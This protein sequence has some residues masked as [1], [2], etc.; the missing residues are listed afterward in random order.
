MSALVYQFKYTPTEKLPPSDIT[1]AFILSVMKWQA[2]CNLQPNIYCFPPNIISPQVPRKI[3]EGIQKM[4]G[5]VG[6]ILQ[7]YINSLGRDF[8]EVLIS[9]G[10]KIAGPFKNFE[11]MTFKEKEQYPLVLSCETFLIAKFVDKNRFGDSVVY[12]T[13][14]WGIEYCAGSYRFEGELLLNVNIKVTLF[15]SLTKEKMIVK[16]ISIPVQPSFYKY[17]IYVDEE[18]RVDPTTG[19]RFAT[20]KEAKFLEGDDQRPQVLAKALESIYPLQLDQFSK[21]FDPKEI[22]QAKTDAEKVRK[23]RGYSEG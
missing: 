23:I 2:F 22:E 14:P 3:Q 5:E 13:Y 15:E 20:L 10:Y 11:D 1:V 8:I 6:K 7:D 18:I 21:I 19:T 4:L 16:E 17:L 12:G 9:K